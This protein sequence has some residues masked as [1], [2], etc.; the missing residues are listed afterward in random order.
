MHNAPDNS[1]SG[2]LL[3]PAFLNRSPFHRSL[4][5]S[6][7]LMSWLLMSWLLMSCL[8]MSWL[9]MS[10][11]LMPSLLTIRHRP[12]VTRFTT[13]PAYRPVTAPAAYTTAPFT[14]TVCTPVAIA[15]GVS[16]VA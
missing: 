11:L 6:W 12:R 5:T 3:L 2:A 13:T 16:N 10:W 1:P 8:L 15:C 4:F 14:H 9:L 7:L